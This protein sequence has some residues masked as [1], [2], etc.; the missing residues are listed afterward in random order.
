MHNLCRKVLLTLAW[1]LAFVEGK[2]GNRKS[3]ETEFCLE[4]STKGLLKVKE[5]RKQV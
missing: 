1:K 5:N 4:R 3:Q 2:Q